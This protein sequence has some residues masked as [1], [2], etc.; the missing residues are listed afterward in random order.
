[1]KP[2]LRK[3][4]IDV[5][6]C[7]TCGVACWRPPAD[8]RARSI[9]DATYFEGAGTARGYDDYATLE[10]ALRSNFRH[11]LRSLRPAA[12]GARLLDIG[13]AFGFC[14]DEAAA[15][16]WDAI[17][18]EVSTE[19]AH[20]AHVRA[21]HRVV[22]GDCAALPF[23]AERFDVV[24]LFDVLEHLPDPHRV[25]SDI[26]RV[27]RP[28]GQLLLTTGDVGSVVA[29]LSGA[30]W[31]LYTLPEHLFFYSRDGIRRLLASHG[32]RIDHVRAESARYP[33]GYLLERVR[34]SCFG[35]AARR[36]P[37]WPGAGITI[38]VNL[39][40]IVSVRAVRTAP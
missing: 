6:Q 31:H 40:D 18:I 30:R 38:P 32:F 8:F 15:A 12:R 26:A 7:A 11:R 21:P 33:L 34:K 27:M 29:R 28:G 10:P 5:L 23:A 24:T 22:V 4:G 36:A 16:G 25:M 1:M 20:R 13:A 19:A 3:D 2:K 39:F 37:A 17:G 35:G 9:Y 14:V